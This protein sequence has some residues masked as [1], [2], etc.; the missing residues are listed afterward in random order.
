MKKNK[1]NIFIVLAA[2]LVIGGA[3]AAKYF[4]DLSSYRQAVE[5]ITIGEVNL[6]TIPDGTYTGSSEAVWVGATVEVTVQ[7]HRIT[8]IKL[9]HRHGQGEAAEVI[10]DHV[11]EAQSL[12]VD[13]ISGVTSSSKVILKA[14]EN[15]LLSATE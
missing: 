1:K 9:D 8:N 13:I 3:F 10:T 2:I 6:A 15:A 12:Q 11:I 7:D 4:S 14:I 5:E